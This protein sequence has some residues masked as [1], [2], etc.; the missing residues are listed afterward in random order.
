[1]TTTVFLIAVFFVLVLLLG[2]G[3]WATG[4]PWECLCHRYPIEDED[5]ESQHDDYL[6]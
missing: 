3:L 2:S 5:G 1:M 6:L 4:W